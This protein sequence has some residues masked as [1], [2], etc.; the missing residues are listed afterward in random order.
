MTFNRLH[1]YRQNETIR[2]MLQETS[3]HVTDFIVP[4]FISEQITK[5]TPVQS[6]PGVV[7]H[8]LQSV[9]DEVAECKALG[10]RMFILFGI[11]KHKDHNGSSAD[12]GNGVIQEA[13]RKI[14]VAHPDVILIADCCLC[15][16]TDHGHCGVLNAEGLLENDSTLERLQSIAISYAR[17]GVDII[18]PSGMMDGMVH[19]IRSGLDHEGFPNVSVMSYAVKYASQLYGPFRDAAGSTFTSTRT[20][21]QLNPAQKEEALVEAEEDIYEG[22]DYLIIKPAGFYHDMI[23]A[24]KALTR[25]PLVAYQVS[26]EYSMYCLS[27]DHGLSNK[28]EL[29]HESFLSLKRAGASLIISYFAKDYATWLKQQ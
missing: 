20:H 26:G 27:A 29:F 24:C 17:A 16:Y 14:K 22:A 10:L 15:E 25:R 8:T 6:M 21:H 19:A 5:I 4:L 28:T 2:S 7:Q 13:I 18:A 11:P 3:V 12:D 23:S 1:R 9:C